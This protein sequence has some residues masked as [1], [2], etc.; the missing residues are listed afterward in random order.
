[1]LFDILFMAEHTLLRCDNYD[2]PQL[3]NNPL[4]QEHTVL[5]FIYLFIYIYCVN[6]D[7]LHLLGRHQKQCRHLSFRKISERRK[8]GSSIICG[9]QHY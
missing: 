7:Y 8:F 6:L 3:H 5:L 2:C 9:C 1:M 4:L